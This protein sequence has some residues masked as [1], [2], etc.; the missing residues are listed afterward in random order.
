[1]R[2]YA[3][4]I[5]LWRGASGLG[6]S[7]ADQIREQGFVV[8]AGDEARQFAPRV[9]TAGRPRQAGQ[10]AGLSPEYGAAVRPPRTWRYPS[11]RRAAC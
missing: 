3:R 1:M 11:E 9:R 8:I 10:S 6:R 7:G 4:A 2:A 5:G